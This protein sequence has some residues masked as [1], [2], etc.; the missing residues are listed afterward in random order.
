MQHKTPQHVPYGELTIISP[1]AIS[2]NNSNFKKQ[3]DAQKKPGFQPS[4]KVSLEKHLR[5]A[6]IIV[7]KIIVKTPYRSRSSLMITIRVI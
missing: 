7:G 3:F 6:E 1:T 2:K 4:G 5:F